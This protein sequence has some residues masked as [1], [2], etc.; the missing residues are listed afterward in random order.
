MIEMNERSELSARDGSSDFIT[1]IESS[2]ITVTMYMGSFSIRSNGTVEYF[3][4]NTKLAKRTGIGG[5]AAWKSVKMALH[6]AQSTPCRSDETVPATWVDV[7]R[8][9]QRSHAVGNSLHKLRGTVCQ[10]MK[11]VGEIP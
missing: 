8:Q 4:K 11:R 3:V 9:P 7:S 1:T 10:R 6:S 5:D 2:S